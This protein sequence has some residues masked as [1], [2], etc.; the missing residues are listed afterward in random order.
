MTLLS[1][2]ASVWSLKFASIADAALMM[3]LGCDGGT[4]FASS[5]PAASSDLSAVFVGSGIFHVCS[6]IS[7]YLSM[8]GT[9]IGSSLT[10]PRS[11]PALLF[12]R[13]DPP[14]LVHSCFGT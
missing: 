8:R 2:V 3:Q 9:E 11:V 14:Y 7:N 1:I 4:Y 12:N 13:Y 5:V 6:V 10:T